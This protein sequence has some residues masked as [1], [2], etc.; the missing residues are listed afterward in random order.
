[1]KPSAIA[2]SRPPIILSAAEIERLYD[3]AMN[4]QEQG[5]SPATL[6]L[7]ELERAEIRPISAMPDNVVRMHSVVRY[8]DGSNGRSRSVILVYPGEA[9]IAVG[10]VSVLTHVGAG[11]IGL[12]ANQSIN[13]PGR[14][15]RARSL[16]V[17]DV[18]PPT[19]LAF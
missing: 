16:D 10:K 3:L 17:L 4:V 2:D 13:W 15:G 9:D 5:E 18:R 6:L 19:R 14:D 11:L 1:M 7:E 12:A 8:R